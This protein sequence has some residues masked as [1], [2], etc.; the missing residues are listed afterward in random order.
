MR[1]VR[2]DAS[3]V[4]VE[5]GDFDT[6]EGRFHPSLVW[7]ESDAAQPGDLWDGDVF[8]TPAAPEASISLQE[9]ALQYDKRLTA[10]FDA[11]AREKN[12]ESRITCALRAGYV[13]PF[14]AEGIA[15]AQWMDSCNAL[16]YQLLAEVQQT[17]IVPSWEEVLEQ[18][19]SMVWP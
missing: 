15:F 10:M 9:A 5:V 6:I 8:T 19:P 18:L 14:Q 7:I 13:G 17:G 3:G 16:A 1:Y 4:V 12:Y 11:K 2:V